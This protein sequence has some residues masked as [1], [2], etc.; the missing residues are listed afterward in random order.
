MKN[1]L[2]YILQ[3]TG[4]SLQRGGWMNGAAVSTITVLLLLLGLSLQVGWQLDRLVGQFG[5]QLEI[6]LFLSPGVA[7]E[8]LLSYVQP[9]AGVESVSVITQD[10]AW[11]RLRTELDL[12]DLET[13]EAQF[14]GNPLVV[15]IFINRIDDPG[16]RPVC[17]ALVAELRVRAKSPE[18]VPDL[19]PQLA[20]LGGVELV[21][22]R[23]DLVE[24]L[25]QVNQGLRGLGL[26]TVLV[27][28][29]TAL[30][31]ITTTIRLVILAQRREIE[32]MQLVGA[33]SAWI[34]LPFLLQGWVFGAVGG[35]IAWGLLLAIQQSLGQF[36]NQQ[37]D[38]LQFLAQGLRL[39]W[40]ELLILPLVLVG[41]GSGVG[42]LGS[43]LAV[44]PLVWGSS[45]SDPQAD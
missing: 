23:P 4:R 30:A 2:T 35:G 3:E 26:G 11:E 42:V 27:L 6:N 44:R 34:C 43:L 19:V 32:I 18:V 8:S 20:A 21:Q 15:T 36:L 22:Y 1:R 41:F 24:R 33:T 12:P 29:L 40:V 14:Q 16:L 31:V 25:E 45:V 13:I 28:T 39:D 9:L 5:N 17:T 10:Q 37:P 38:F 7:G